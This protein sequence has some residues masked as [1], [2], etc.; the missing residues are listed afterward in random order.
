MAENLSSADRITSISRD[1]APVPSA[2]EWLVGGWDTPKLLLRIAKRSLDIVLSL[3]GLIL[4]LPFLAVVILVIAIDSP[5][6]PL[7]V[8]RRVGRYGAPFGLIKLR[9][10]MPRAEERLHDYLASSDD[11]LGEWQRARK[12]RTDPRV[13]RVGRFL[14]RRSL[15]EIPQLI[16]VFFGQMSLVGPRPVLPEEAPLFGDSLPVVLSVRPGLTGLWAVSGRAE[17]SYEERV[18]LEATYVQQC[19]LR[20]DLS[21]MA[22]T[23]PWV[24]KG[25]GAY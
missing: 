11:L 23:I 3:A 2:A 21:I 18:A 4:V 16:N 14:R 7:Y 19:N 5:G 9:T 1:E 17:L 13:T 15:D 12:L 10:M 25:T 22:R 24:L 20:A 6:A 8:Q